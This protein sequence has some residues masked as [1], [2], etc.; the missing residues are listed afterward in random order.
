MISKYIIIIGCGT[1][2]STLANRLSGSGHSIVVVDH[3]EVSFEQLG[4]EFSGFKIHGDAN[5]FF[6]LRQAKVDKAEIVLA[7]TDDDNLNIMLSQI[8]RQIYKIPEVIARVNKPGAAELFAKLGIK[9]ICP[10]LLAVDR[11]LDILGSA[12]GTEGEK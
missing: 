11:F 8:C 12:N 9:T 7:L 10:T 1:L 5:E 3:S 2:G 4:S 6:V